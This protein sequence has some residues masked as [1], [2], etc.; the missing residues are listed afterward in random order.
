[1]T[2]HIFDFLGQVFE[3][4]VSALGWLIDLAGT[5]ISCLLKGV[6]ADLSTLQSIFLA[7]FRLGA[8]VFGVPVQWTPLFL[9]GGGLLI[10]FLLVLI[11]WAMAVRAKRKNH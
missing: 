7:P 5:A 10:L 2:L 4:A 1:M 3:A 9:L 6:A 11:G 8:D